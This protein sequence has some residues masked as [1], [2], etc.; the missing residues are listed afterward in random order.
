M[1]SK[2]MLVVDTVESVSCDMLLRCWL[3]LWSRKG[4]RPDRSVSSEYVDGM[5]R[6][7]E[8][9]QRVSLLLYTMHNSDVAVRSGGID[10]FTGK[11]KVLPLNSS[12]DCAAGV[13]C[14]VFFVGKMNL[15]GKT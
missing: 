1:R 3:G 5:V 15:R 6:M 8:E 14:N 9:R 2:T 13:Q 7:G 4:S 12:K 10:P 11:E